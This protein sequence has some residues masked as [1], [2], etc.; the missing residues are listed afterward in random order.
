MIPHLRELR[1]RAERAISTMLGVPTYVA[2]G[3]ELPPKLR[4]GHYFAYTRLGIGIVVQ[5]HLGPRNRGPGPAMV[6]DETFLGRHTRALAHG[7]FV[8]RRVLAGQIFLGVVAH[9]VA[10]V[11]ETGWTHE[12]DSPSASTAEIAEITTVALLAQPPVTSVERPIPFLNHDA[13]FV[14]LMLH[15]HTRLQ[16]ALGIRFE[17]CFD[18]DV[19]GM[20]SVGK[21]QSRLSDEPE[22][23]AHMPLTEIG[24]V[25]PPEAFA[26]LWRADVRRWWNERRPSDAN[27][28]AMITALRLFTPF[29]P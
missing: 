22:R 11:T 20:S 16:T 12:L 4:P 25:Q 19:Y 29:T 26:E 6:V 23:L 1:D 8:R 9:E 24:D 14:R 18:G 3:C 27:T 10:H 15:V 28:D 17:P 5:P 21:Y 7:R 2:F 13:G